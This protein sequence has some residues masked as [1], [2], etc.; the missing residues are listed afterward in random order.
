VQ[1]FLRA[2]N[3]I[4]TASLNSKLKKEGTLDRS[5]MWHAW[6]DEKGVHNL[7]PNAERSFGTW[8]DVG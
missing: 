7:S 3:L 6:G 1:N 2:Y 5:S 4:L 8:G